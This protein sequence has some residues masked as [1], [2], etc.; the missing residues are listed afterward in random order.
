MPDYTGYMEKELVIIKEDVKELKEDNAKLYTY[1][2]TLHEEAMSMI[3]LLAEQQQ[4]TNKILE[5]FAINVE[6]QFNK[7]FDAV[8]ESKVTET[9]LQD[10][11]HR[12]VDRKE[13]ESRLKPLEARM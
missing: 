1:M 10:Q 2:G 12:K 8:G 7:L 4:Q 3:S 11:I 5:M 9:E 13:F 6:E